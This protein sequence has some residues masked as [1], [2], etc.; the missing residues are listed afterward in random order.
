MIVHNPP[1]FW[2]AFEDQCEASM[3]LVVCALQAPAAEYHRRA[4]GQHVHLTCSSCGA[5]D[6]LSMRDAASLKRLIGRHRG[7][8]ADFT[9]F[10]KVLPITLHQP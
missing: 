4:E 8:E 7:F 2:Q 5:T 10:A 6:T 3:R 1:A 9:H